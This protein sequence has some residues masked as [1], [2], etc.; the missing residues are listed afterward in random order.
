[1]EGLAGWD[2]GIVEIEEFGHVVFGMYV[3]QAPTTSSL[4]LMR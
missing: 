4:L 2:K 1:M 3:Q